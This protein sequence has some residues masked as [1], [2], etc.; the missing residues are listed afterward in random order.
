MFC[1]HCRRGL[2]LALQIICIMYAWFK[3][4]EPG[5]DIGGSGRKV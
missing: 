4:I 1:G 5:T 2:T 3:R